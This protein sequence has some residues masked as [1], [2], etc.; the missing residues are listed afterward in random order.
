MT[1]FENG[2]FMAYGMCHSCE[3]MEY[4]QLD[5]RITPSDFMGGTAAEVWGDV[6]H[7]VM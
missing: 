2:I 3:L 1:G 6:T 4:Y 7:E 5:P